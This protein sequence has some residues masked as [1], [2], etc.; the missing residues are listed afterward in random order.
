MQRC[1]VVFSGRVQGVGFRYTACRAAAP[2][3]VTGYVQNLPTGEVKLVAEGTQFE[4]EQ[5]L[6][7]LDERMGDNIDDQTE[8]WL[9]S[10]GDFRQFEIKY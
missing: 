9:P 4:I 1:E 5:L 10:S 2:L 7:S 3:A 8:R 6:A